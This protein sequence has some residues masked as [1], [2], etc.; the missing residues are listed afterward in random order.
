MRR[1]E[2][3]LGDYVGK[4]FEFSRPEQPPDRVGPEGGHV[5]VGYLGAV[6]NG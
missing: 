5:V 2:S 3:A 4:G 6:C 1:A